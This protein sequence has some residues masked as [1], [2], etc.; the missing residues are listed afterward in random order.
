MIYA[1]FDILYAM[2]TI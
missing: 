2:T 1:H